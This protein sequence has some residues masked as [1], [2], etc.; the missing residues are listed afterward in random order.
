MCMRKTQHPSGAL[1]LSAQTLIS[2]ARRE[3]LHCRKSLH[4][5]SSTAKAADLTCLA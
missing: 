3:M 1:F 2:D 4:P 5:P